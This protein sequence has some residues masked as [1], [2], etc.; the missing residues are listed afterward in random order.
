[1]HSGRSAPEWPTRICPVSG[2]FEADYCG[3]RF[4]FFAEGDD[5]L[6]DLLYY[7]FKPEEAEL[8]LFEALARRSRVV[9]D[10]GAN[11]GLYSV[12]GGLTNPQARSFAFEPHPAN[13]ARLL[14]NLELNGLSYVEALPQAVGRECG[15][16]RFSIPADGSVSM[17]AS[18]DPAF[19]GTFH[20]GGTKAV[21]VGCTT[22]D[23]FVAERGLERVDL[24]KLDVEYHEEAVLEGARETLARA[25][26]V[27]LCEVLV[28]DFLVARVPEVE[29]KIDP[30]HWQRLEHLL[31]EA[32]YR[33]YSI[34]DRGLLRV[35][36]LYSAPQ[37]DGYL[38][39]K[40]ES[41]RRFLPYQ[42]LE[43]AADELLG[44]QPP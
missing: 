25:G 43:R 44:P 38:F 30:G 7:G 26:P 11:T 2:V 42:E 8:R 32:G 36:S 23:A 19:A 40:K 4:R 13:H 33:F 21:E 31:G 10:V 34:G 1:M 28:Y 35:D 17:I 37:H 6:A 3:R 29:G 5:M 22:L 41:A 18:A 20:H 24:V 27:L 16:L 9:L 12:I 15:P 14:R 39:S